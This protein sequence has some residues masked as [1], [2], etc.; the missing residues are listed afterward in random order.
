MN[1]KN[2]KWTKDETILCMNFYIK[3]RNKIPNKSSSEL[4]ELHKLIQKFNQINNTSGTDTFRNHDGIYMKL[5]NIMHL[6]PQAPSGLPRNSNM[7]KEV[8]NEYSND[9]QRL[10]I[11][12]KKIEEI[13]E[14]ENPFLR[15][16]NIDNEYE[17][18]EGQ[19][20][21]KQHK[22]YE[23]DSKLINK[24]KEQVLKSGGKLICEVCNFDFFRKY[25]ERGHGFIECHHN[26]PVSTI[27]KGYKTKLGDLSLL[28]A[29]CHRMIHKQKPWLSIQELR[30]LV[31][32]GV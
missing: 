9:T 32:N 19:I 29:N 7:D 4:N 28:C 3:Y 10:S 31:N 2:P 6:D 1:T 11:V 5:M 27:P 30:N 16:V 22:V 14:T 23:R 17:A 13:V 21:T 24:K 25:G 15:S 12:A 20:I 26:I 8:W 18:S